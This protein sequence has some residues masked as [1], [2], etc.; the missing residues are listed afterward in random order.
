MR[1]G[2]RSGF[3][4]STGPLLIGA[5]AAVLLIVG[6]VLSSAPDPG[7]P[8]LLSGAFYVV[9]GLLVFGLVAGGYATFLFPLKLVVADDITV[10]FIH[11]K[12]RLMRGC[13]EPLEDCG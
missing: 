6:L 10:V 2:N 7:N 12:R 3:R 13:R 9:L 1:N 4:L 8:T 5:L 11:K